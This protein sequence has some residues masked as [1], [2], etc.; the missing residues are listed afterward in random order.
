MR[1]KTWIEFDPYSF[2][3]VMFYFNL[4]TILKRG[5]EGIIILLV[6]MKK[7]AQRGNLP[8]THS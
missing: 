5:I 3:N 8:R 1:K 2:L 7:H 4:F 6:Q